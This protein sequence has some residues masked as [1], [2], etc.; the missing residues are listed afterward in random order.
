MQ[1]TP[2]RNHPAFPVLLLMFAI[3]IVLLLLYY[4]VISS[5]FASLGLTGKQATL[6]LLASLIGSSINIPLTRRRIQLADPQQARMSPAMRQLVTIF[7]YYPPMVVQEVV[8]INLGGALIPIGF[9]IYLLVMGKA[10][11]PFTALALV[12]V[13]VVAKLLARPVPG[14]GITLPGYIPPLVAAA[15]A[16]ILVRVIH[17]GTMAAAAPIAYIAGSL[18][19][20]IGA[21][22]LNLPLVLRGGLLAAGPMRLFPGGPARAVPANQPRILSIGG[23]GIFDGVFLAGVVAAFLAAR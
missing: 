3:P 19:A 22:L 13:V 16:I 23:A 18:G 2:A 20:L 17:S 4:N 7:H 1:A 15:A 11:I 12:A 21:D 10:D 5:S 6:L 14:L 9:S 8:A